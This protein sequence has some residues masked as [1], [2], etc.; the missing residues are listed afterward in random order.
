MN[1]TTQFTIL[2][3]SVFVLLSLTSTAMAGKSITQA[4]VNL[5]TPGLTTEEDLVR[6]FGQPTT[7]TVCPPGQVTLDWFYATPMGAQNYIPFIGAAFGGAQLNAWELWVVLR[8]N[9]TVKHFIA[10][11]RYMDGKTVP[12]VA[13]SGYSIQTDEGIRGGQF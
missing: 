4:K 6:A 3:F 10:Y 7:K 1:K 12:D 8:A 2:A 5:I 9:G 13:R 11:R